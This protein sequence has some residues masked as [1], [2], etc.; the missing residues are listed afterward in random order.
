M[1]H[2]CFPR[3]STMAVAGL[4]LSQYLFKTLQAMS[5]TEERGSGL[6]KVLTNVPNLKA[7]FI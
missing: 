1:T 2:D 3:C 6:Q 7:A 4:V 5:A